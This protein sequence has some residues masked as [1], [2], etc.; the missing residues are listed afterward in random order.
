MQKIKRERTILWS[1]M[2]MGLTIATGTIVVPTGCNVV[3]P[4]FREFTQPLEQKTSPRLLPYHRVE[5]Q[6]RQGYFD[7]NGFLVLPTF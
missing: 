5:N 7:E 6:T 4:E 3:P 2:I 1:V